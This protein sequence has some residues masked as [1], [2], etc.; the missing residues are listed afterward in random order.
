L[1]NEDAAD[2]LTEH[3][4]V[5]LDAT[6]LLLERCRK[7]ARPPK[8]VFTSSLAVFGGPLPDPV[9]DDADDALVLLDRHLGELPEVLDGGLQVPV[10]VEGHRAGHL[11][12]RVH[13]D[14]VA[15][16]FIERARNSS[17]SFALSSSAITASSVA[18]RRV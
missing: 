4:A 10:G 6:R 9:P 7:L 15:R 16:W 14:R 13:V 12:R 2:A 18:G 11:A 1:A 3:Q 5:I 8:F 17:N